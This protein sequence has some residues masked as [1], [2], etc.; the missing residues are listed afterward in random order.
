MDVVSTYDKA[1]VKFTRVSV[2][3][4]AYFWI[5]FIMVLRVAW[6]DVVRQLDICTAYGRG[7]C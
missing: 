3:F 7:E 6:S 4:T 2:K 5:A 1:I